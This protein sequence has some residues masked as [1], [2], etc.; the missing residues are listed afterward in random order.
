MSNLILQGQQHGWVETGL[1]IQAN[2][3]LLVKAGGEIDFAKPAGKRGPDGRDETG[4]FEIADDSHPAPGFRKNS[5]VMGVSGWMDHTDVLM[6]ARVPVKGPV[7]MT[8]NDNES[9]DNDG[10]W[11]VDVR[12]W[13]PDAKRVTRVIVEK[14]GGLTTV[15][16]EGKF[17]GLPRG[18]KPRTMQKKNWH[19]FHNN[20]ITFSVLGGVQVVL[21]NFVPASKPYDFRYSIDYTFDIPEDVGFFYDTYSGPKPVPAELIDWR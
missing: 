19:D 16:V 18:F 5:L 4:Q 10:H 12:R 2:E 14:K 13:R 15:T 11:W 8:H 20:R 1:N 17:H 3:W 9:G 7:Y 6:A 21:D